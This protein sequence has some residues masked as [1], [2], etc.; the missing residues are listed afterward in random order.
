M[1]HSRVLPDDLRAELVDWRLTLESVFEGLAANPRAVGDA[2]LEDRLPAK[3]RGLESHVEK[4]M[5]GP[6]GERWSGTEE[7][8]V[9]RLL[10]AVR[11]VSD[12]LV[13]YER[14]ARAIDWRRLSE[15]RF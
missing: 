10:A 6:A 13:A 14:E 1:R 7:Q 11:E 2:R 12:G 9:Y 3:I 15:S 8:S 4:L 5:N